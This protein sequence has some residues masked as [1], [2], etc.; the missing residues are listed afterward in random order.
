[1][2]DSIRCRTDDNGFYSYLKG[3]LHFQNIQPSSVI[4]A[5]SQP[6]SQYPYTYFTESYSGKKNGAKSRY[7]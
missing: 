5:D 1:M 7:L 3:N 2:S 4:T 6:L